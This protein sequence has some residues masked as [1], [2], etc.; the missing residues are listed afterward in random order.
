MPIEPEA[1]GQ[2]VECYNELIGSIHEQCKQAIQEEPSTHTST[3]ISRT[4]LVTVLQSSNS[5]SIDPETQVIRFD[6]GGPDFVSPISDE[7][8]DYNDTIEG[9]RLL[10]SWANRHSNG[11]GEIVLDF[12]FSVE[13]LETLKDFLIAFD[14][15]LLKR[16]K[17]VAMEDKRPEVDSATMKKAFDLVAES[18][19]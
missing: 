4:A 6:F 9:W 14:I 18:S 5:Y 19:R 8:K 17:T 15:A 16:A 2:R 1:F 7:L 11:S 10:S 3:K 13:A 12:P